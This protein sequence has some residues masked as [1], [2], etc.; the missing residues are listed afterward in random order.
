MN[1]NFMVEVFRAKQ[2]AFTLNELSVLTGVKNYNSLKRIANYYSK[3]GIISNIRRGFYV[4]DEFNTYELAVKIYP[5]AYI[6]FETVLLEEGVIFQYD[7]TVTIA[8]YLSREITVGGNVFRYR[9]LKDT[10]LTSPQ[11]LVFKDRYT[12][13][14]KERAFLDILY[15]NKDFYVD[16]MEKL[17]KKRIMEIVE[18]YRNLSLERKVKEIF[19]A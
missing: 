7:R 13:A 10:V 15:L 8:S 2:S 3:K 5:P 12:I 4:K 6:G 11:G 18:I 17:D 19:N 9:K 1:K 16:H 14:E